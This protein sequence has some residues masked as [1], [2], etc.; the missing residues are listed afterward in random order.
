MAFVVIA[1]T[2]ATYIYNERKPDQFRASTQ[3]FL[4][5]SEIDQ[6]LIGVGAFMQG[7][8]NIANQASLLQTPEVA[9]E[10]AK[11]IGFQGDPRAL[12]DSVTVTPAEGSDFLV[13]T[14]VDDDPAGAAQMANAFA[15]A[16]VNLRAATTR[17]DVQRALETARRQFSR[18]PTTD[19]TSGARE[20]LRTRINSLE[21]IQSLDAGGARQVDEA[22]PPVARFAPQ[23]RRA[24]LFGFMISLVLAVLAS[25]G[26]ERLDRRV[27]H[28]DEMEPAYGARVLAALP[29][30]KGRTV[31][32]S[33]GDSP[34]VAP[35]LREAVRGLRTNLQLASPDKPLRTFLVTSALPGEGKSTLV[36]NLALAYAQSGLRVVIIECDLRLPSMAKLMAIKSS[37][38]LTDVLAGECDL[39]AAVQ[40][41]EVGEPVAVPVPDGDGQSTGPSAPGAAAL[42]VLTGGAHPADPSSLMASQAM[43]RVLESARADADLVII[44]SPPLLA[45]PD[46]L[47]LVGSVDATI[48]VARV[49]LTTRPAGRRVRE[50]IEGIPGASLLGVVANDVPAA[51]FSGYGYGYGYGGVSNG[52]RS[53]GSP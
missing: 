46:A 47:P 30:L 13:V 41:V 53:A 22:V 26:L 14:A 3:V 44:D 2:V 50:I 35:A 9:R 5:A 39:A 37:P 40:R 20:T 51:D 10:V 42:T 27:K 36:L 23:P 18:L 38:G 49:G 25:F 17:A 15:G 1:T 48:L 11:D 45:V 29:H 7:D 43:K 34:E 12:L 28:L 8:R 31:S 6:T 32:R 24:A 4:Q 21:A 19:A 52:A 33:N 16:F